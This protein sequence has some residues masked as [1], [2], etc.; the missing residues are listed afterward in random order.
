MA[1][2]LLADLGADVV[3]IER[4]GVGDV[5]RNRE[6]T[7]GGRSY[8]FMMR[9]HS[10]DSVAL[11]LKHEAGQEAFLDLAADADVV[12]EAFR[13]GVVDRLGVGY[14][15]VSDVN[16]NIVYCSITG[17]GDD[18][19]YADRPGHDM[20][21][22]GVSGLLALT[23]E[24]DGDPMFPGYAVADCASAIYAAFAISAATAG[25]A[26]GA[27]GE[28]IDVS[29][30]DAVASFGIILGPMFF[31]RGVEPRRENTFLTGA[32]PGCAAYETADGSYLSFGALE[33]RFWRS[34]CEAVGLSDLGEIRFWEEDIE[35]ET[36]DQA[37][38]ALADRLSSR[39]ADEWVEIFD[40][41]DV[42]VAPVNGYTEMFED[43]QL[44][45]RE[46]FERATLSES[47]E[48]LVY[49][50]TPVCFDGER[51]VEKTPAPRLGAD[52][53][54]R[55]Q[56]VGYDPGTLVELEEAGALSLRP[57]SYPR[58]PPN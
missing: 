19:P 11:N 33:Q 25:V 52:T 43:P 51:K 55:L 37:R 14:G 8:A 18:G 30:T 41:H 39:S 10:K 49:F 5:T 40:D 12:V 13:P 32:H 20:N 56:Q 7:I 31:G 28:Y 38:E 22:I 36:V 54:T 24:S 27:G 21:Y 57:T 16:E 3:K 47:D 46:V 17:Y 23:G 2:M 45:R 50:D 29:M 42:P 44:Q 4:P 15:D 6:P 58:R 1:T 35:E 48:E 53:A 34:L 26:H 9:N